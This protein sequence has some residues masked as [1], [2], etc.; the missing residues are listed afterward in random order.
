MPMNPDE[1]VPDDPLPEVPMTE[2]IERARSLA[3]RASLMR[4]RGELI[5]AM[6]ARDMSWREIEAKTGIPHGSARRWAALYLEAK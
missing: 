2:L 5:V 1:R 6:K 3:D 4:T